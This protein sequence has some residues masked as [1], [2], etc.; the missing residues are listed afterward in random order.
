MLTV[1]RLTYTVEEAARLFGISRGLAYELVKSGDLPAVRLGRRLVV[2]RM[3]VE[4]LLAG[5]GVDGPGQEG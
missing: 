3:V 5:A 4:R 1:H 2:P